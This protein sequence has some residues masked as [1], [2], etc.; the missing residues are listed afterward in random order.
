MGVCVGFDEK[1]QNAG[2][3][4][5]YTAVISCYRLYISTVLIFILDTILSYRTWLALQPGDVATTK[6]CVGGGMK[7]KE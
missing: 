3:L 4:N 6:L 5:T 2:V 7:I 1:K